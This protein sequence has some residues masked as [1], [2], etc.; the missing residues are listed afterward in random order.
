MLD[1]RSFK[2]SCNYLLLVSLGVVEI[3]VH[4]IA[5]FNGLL[6]TVAIGL[7]QMFI[8]VLDSVHIKKTVI[9]FIF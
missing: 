8:F 3:F 9:F 7:W 4:G 5:K 1:G 6:C 2:I